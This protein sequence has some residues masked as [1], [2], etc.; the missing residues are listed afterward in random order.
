MKH[1]ILQVIEWTIT[2]ASVAFLVWV[3]A[4][5]YATFSQDVPLS[6]EQTILQK[7]WTGSN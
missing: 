7:Y 6:G 5:L 3:L 1:I 4:C 2:I